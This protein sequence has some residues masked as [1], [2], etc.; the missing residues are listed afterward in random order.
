MIV[1]IINIL[2]CWLIAFGAFKAFQW[3]QEFGTKFSLMM[4]YLLFLTSI[5]MSFYLMNEF[6]NILSQPIN[7]R[8]N[9]YETVSKVV[10]ALFLVS[11]TRKKR[12]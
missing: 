9:N 11:F 3:S 6:N 1:L 5:F 4:N 12:E 8:L 2:A 10:F 7:E